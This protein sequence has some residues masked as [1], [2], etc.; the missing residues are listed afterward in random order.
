ME[1]GAARAMEELQ[2]RL[3]DAG[4]E[5]DPETG[6]IS[7]GA[8][9]IMDPDPRRK[10]RGGKK[11][12]HASLAKRKTTRRAA[13]W[14]HRL[15][16]HRYLDPRPSFRGAARR[17]K[18]P[19]TKMLTKAAPFASIGG[20]GLA[21]YLKYAK[22]AKALGIGVTDAIVLDAKNLDFK[23]ATDRI[24][25]NAGEIA[26]PAIVGYVLKQVP[27]GPAKIRQ[28]LGNGMMGASGG[29]LA[30]HFLDPPIPGQNQAQNQGGFPM[31]SG[32]GIG[33]APQSSGV[34]TYGGL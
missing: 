29:I 21:F 11:S 17:A 18:D 8:P 30:G 6:E 13:A 12:R 14:H 4:L 25:A 9:A 19:L 28:L 26:T 23:A 16:T 27:I 15:G 22:R 31:N 5:I 10:R 1:E 3:D 34:P 24:I 20:A 32:A 2:D 33:G 7:P